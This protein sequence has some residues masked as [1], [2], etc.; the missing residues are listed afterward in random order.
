MIISLLLFLQ[1]LS[2]LTGYI[3]LPHR[4]AEGR[5]YAEILERLSDR[6]MEIVDVLRGIIADDAVSPNSLFGKLKFPALIDS[7]LGAK[8]ATEELCDDADHLYFVDQ[9]DYVTKTIPAVGFMG[10]LWV[11]VVSQTLD[12]LPVEA[13]LLSKTGEDA[14]AEADALVGTTIPDKEQMEDAPM[15]PRMETPNL[16]ILERAF[17]ILYNDWFDFRF[18]TS[19]FS[20]ET[21][22]INERDKHGKET[23]LYKLR[24]VPARELA[25][26]ILVHLPK[27]KELVACLDPTAFKGTEAENAILE[28]NLHVIRSLLAHLKS[29]KPLITRS[30][31]PD[32][33]RFKS[34]L[35]KV[36]L[37]L[38]DITTEMNTLND[39]LALVGDTPETNRLYELKKVLK[40]KSHDFGSLLRQASLQNAEHASK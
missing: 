22:L 20:A 6:T 38:T 9:R 15:S 12:L 28:P 17:E 37:L 21:D 29:I 5:L 26:I 11:N 19:V 2:V 31:E 4:A 23:F 7:F 16:P 10:Y 30:T 13:A 1:P 8:V 25:R 14:V 39:A 35:P 18:A 33:E 24:S 34:N 3:D 32:V 40:I 36:T 27:T